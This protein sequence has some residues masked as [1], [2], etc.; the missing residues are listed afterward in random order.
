M[1]KWL[2]DAMGRKWWDS[3]QNA[4]WMFHHDNASAHLLQLIQEFLEKHNIFQS[5]H[6]LLLWFDHLVRIEYMKWRSVKQLFRKL[7]SRCVAKSLMIA[8]VM[9]TKNKQL[10]RNITVLTKINY[11][12]TFRWWLFTFRT[13]PVM[14]WSRPSLR[15]ATSNR[16]THRHSCFRSPLFL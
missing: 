15:T 6:Y 1:L 5:R 10:D 8:R 4:N 2:S 3:R 11:F 12:F 7:N 14:L 16:L 9:A 13:N